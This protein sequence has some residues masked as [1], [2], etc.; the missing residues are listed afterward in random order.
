[1]T[2]KLKADAAP[3]D[4]VTVSEEGVPAS[5]PVHREGCLPGDRHELRWVTP[6][7]QLACGESLHKD[8][9]GRPT[10]LRKGPCEGDTTGLLPVL[11]LKP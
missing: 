8:I 10:D 4:A 11:E 9:R 2:P 1:L 3:I 7:V 6:Q 5:D